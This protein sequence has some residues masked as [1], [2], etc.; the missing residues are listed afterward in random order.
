[1]K[2]ELYFYIV[3]PKTARRTPYYEQGTYQSF[4]VLAY[5]VLHTRFYDH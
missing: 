4:E 3:G 2:M 1:M 5:L